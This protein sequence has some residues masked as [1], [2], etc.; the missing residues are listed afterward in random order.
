MST[1]VLWT[2]INPDPHQLLTY[3]GNHHGVDSALL[4]LPPE[5][6]LHIFDSITHAPSQ[7]AFALTCKRTAALAQRTD[8]NLSL[9]SP[10]YAGFLP[11]SVFDVPDLMVQ[12][13]AWMPPHLRLCGH[14]LTY[15]PFSEKFWQSV[16]GHERNDFWV[17]QQLSS[18]SQSI[19]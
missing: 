10:R 3:D 14:C 16:P 4:S 19:N 9:A 11:V 1:P 2:R 5:V 6:L 7:I 12:L 15:R 18:C 17:S 13:K 8:L